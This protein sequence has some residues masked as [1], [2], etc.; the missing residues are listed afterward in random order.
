MNAKIVVVG[1]AT[2][3]RDF[4]IWFLTLRQQTQGICP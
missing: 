4:S 1:C 3:M 2:A